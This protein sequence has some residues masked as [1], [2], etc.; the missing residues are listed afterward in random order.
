[1]IRSF[2][3]L[4]TSLLMAQAVIATGS[5][6]SPGHGTDANPAAATSLFNASWPNMDRATP[7]DT[8]IFSIAF[9]HDITNLAS[10]SLQLMVD[11]VWSNHG[12]SGRR[13]RGIHATGN[14]GGANA[15][16]NAARIANIATLQG[17]PAAMGWSMTFGHFDGSQNGSFICTGGGG[18]D[19]EDVADSGGF[20]TDTTGLGMGFQWGASYLFRTFPGFEVVKSGDCTSDTDIYWHAHAYPWRTRGI[21]V[22]SIPWPATNEDGFDAVMDSVEASLPGW[23]VIL[24]S[25]AMMADGGNSGATDPFDRAD[26]TLCA[27]HIK[28]TD[29]LWERASVFMLMTSHCPES[30]D[31]STKTQTSSGDTVIGCVGDWSTHI[32][33]GDVGDYFVAEIDCPNDTVI[34]RTIDPINNDT[35]GEDPGCTYAPAGDFEDDPTSPDCCN[36][37]AP[38][39]SSDAGCH[40]VWTETDADLDSRGMC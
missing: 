25:H 8:G 7:K 26:A 23:P 27:A 28:A 37:T 31:C 3:M 20:T 4:L 17:I 11:N 12:V 22:V 10:A 39:G 1:M 34:V 29:Y 21:V 9:F 38:Y 6:P 30:P 35:S 16:T 18:P 19:P 5:W 13:V 33:H 24:A 14:L 32:F 36:Y 2:I 40:E 15:S